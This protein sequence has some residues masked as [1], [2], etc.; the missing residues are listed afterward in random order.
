MFQEGGWEPEET[1]VGRPT[2]ER[3]VEKTEK[4][5]VDITLLLPVVEDERSWG[6]LPHHHSRISQQFADNGASSTATSFP[7][8]AGCREPSVRVSKTWPT[9]VG[10]CPPR[11]FS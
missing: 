2:N 1:P 4:A 7:P 8:L 6:S 11:W 3:K 9:S 10:P 5:E